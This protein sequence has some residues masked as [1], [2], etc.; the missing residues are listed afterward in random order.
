M[1]HFFVDLL[2]QKGVACFHTEGNALLLGIRECSI[3]V[4]GHL[5]SEKG[6]SKVSN[7]KDHTFLT[8][9]VGLAVS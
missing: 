8:G 7:F 2:A 1:D 4:A 5:D 3:D 6:S 9:E